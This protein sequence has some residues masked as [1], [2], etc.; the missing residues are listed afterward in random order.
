MSYTLQ[1]IS[2]MYGY[3]YPTTRR[4]IEKLKEEKKFEPTS[5]GRFL[6]QVDAEAL[7]KLLG[8]KLKVKA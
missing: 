5:V 6:N 7:S 2:A 4:H 3:S 8:F 1:Q